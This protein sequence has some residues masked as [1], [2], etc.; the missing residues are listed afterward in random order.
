[1]LQPQ[2]KQS[3]HRQRPRT[4]SL[5][6]RELLKIWEQGANVGTYD[7]ENGVERIDVEWAGFPPGTPK[8]DVWHWFDEEFYFGVGETVFEFNRFTW[9]NHPYM[10]AR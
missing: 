7:D 3:S 8:E 6:D 1:M 9:T 4:L 10:E 5:Y 2:Q